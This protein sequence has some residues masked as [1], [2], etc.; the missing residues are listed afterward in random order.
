MDPRAKGEMRRKP[1]RGEKT[2]ERRKRKRRKM[3]QAM[4]PWS[5]NPM[6][7]ARP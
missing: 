2:R 6:G 1:K 5:C 7:F 4:Q 3:A